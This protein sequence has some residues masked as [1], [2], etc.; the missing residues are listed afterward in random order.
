MPDTFFDFLERNDIVFQDFE[1][2]GQLTLRLTQIL[3]HSP[4]GGQLPAAIV[5]LQTQRQQAIDLGFTVD[6]FIRRGQ[7]VTQ[8][9]DAR[10]RFV[11]SGARDIA[12]RLAQASG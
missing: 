7:Q 1:S 5:I 10:G 3:G 2:A 9:R 8:L 11:A 4:I 12:A 6:R